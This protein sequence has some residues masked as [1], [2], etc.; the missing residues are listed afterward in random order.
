MIQK[1]DYVAGFLFDQSLVNVALVEKQKPEWQRGFHNGIGGK[2]E[3]NETAD[4]AMRREFREETSVDIPTWIHFCTLIEPMP[5][6]SEWSVEFFYA[7]ASGEQ[8]NGLQSVTEETIRAVRISEIGRQ[9]SELYGEVK[10]MPNL[11]WLIPMALNSLYGEDRCTVFKTQE[12][13]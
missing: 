7:I 4:Q 1:I 5:A 10:L 9:I 13:A 11:K 6:P 3:E 12:I 8:F 2:I